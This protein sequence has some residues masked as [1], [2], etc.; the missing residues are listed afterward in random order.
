MLSVLLILGH[1][2]CAGLNLSTLS[3]VGSVMVGMWESGLTLVGCSSLGL[4]PISMLTLVGVV[5]LNRRNNATSPTG[6]FECRVPAMGSGAL[7]VASI[8]I[9]GQILQLQWNDV[10]VKY[11]CLYSQCKN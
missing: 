8:T 1:L 3:A 2:W 11:P 6:A 4:I 9:I 10:F 7:V 5:R